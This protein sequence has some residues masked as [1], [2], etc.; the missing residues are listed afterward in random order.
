MSQ[1][2]ISDQI[3]K[4][5]NENDSRQIL[6]MKLK[7]ESNISFSAIYVSPNE[8]QLSLSALFKTPGFRKQQI[9]PS[10]VE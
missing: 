6:Q 1:Q 4:S 8:V 5:R 3:T 9:K 2:L 10:T 7:L